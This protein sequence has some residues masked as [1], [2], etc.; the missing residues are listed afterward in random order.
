MRYREKSLIALFLFVVV[1]EVSALTPAFARGGGAANIMGSPG[2][3]RALEESRK[4]YRESYR[5]P[6]VHS[7]SA[8]ARKKYRHR[9]Q[10]Y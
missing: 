10:R 7:P 1:A 4:R 9:G 3:Q 8:H 5:Q 2:Y 6:Y